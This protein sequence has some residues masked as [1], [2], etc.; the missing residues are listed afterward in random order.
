MEETN[1]LI[2]EITETDYKYGFVSDIDTEIIPL[3]LSEETV[4]I[5]SAKKMSLILCLNLD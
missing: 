3:G 2:N 4:R 5:I 1:K